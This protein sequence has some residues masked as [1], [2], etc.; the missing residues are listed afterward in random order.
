MKIKV[1]PLLI[2]MA[3]MLCS[4]GFYNEFICY[5][6]SI[7]LHEFA[8]AQVALKLGYS[9]NVIKLMPH[10]ASLTGSF[11]GVKRSDEI[12][13]A[14][15]GP[16][17]NVV[18]AVVFIALWWLIP[19]T[20]FITEIFVISNIS[21]AVFNILPVF[22]LDGGRVLLAFLSKWFKRDKI[23]F[24]MRITGVIAA[25]MF[26]V[27]FALSIIYKMNI[28]FASVGIFVFLSSVF[29]DKS[30]KYQ[31]LYAMAFR[32]EKIKNGLVVKEIMVKKTVTFLELTRL[33]NGNYFHRFIITDENFKTLYVLTESELET[34]SLKCTD[35]TKVYEIL[36][37]KK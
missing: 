26:C 19:D 20:Y 32:S 14:L 27:F 22:P 24:Y 3:V 5:F 11:E 13:I 7:V 34:L 2:I 18:L 1:S 6:I 9:L 33:I 37:L 21:A 30:S 10:G 16:L 36:S 15:A 28:T 35:N 29:P 25:G 17:M 31:R 8:H 23:Y 12:L 4:L